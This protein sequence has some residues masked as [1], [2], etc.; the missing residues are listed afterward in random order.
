MDFPNVS[1]GVF[2]SNIVILQTKYSLDLKQ[3][4][5]RGFMRSGIAFL[6]VF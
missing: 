5:V 2:L 6:V 1:E 3:V 4:K